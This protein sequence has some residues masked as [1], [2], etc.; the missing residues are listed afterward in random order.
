VEPIVENL[1]GATATAA[2]GPDGRE[3][4]AAFESL[5]EGSALTSFRLSIPPE[6]LGLRVASLGSRRAKAQPP[7][8]A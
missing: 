2:V 6:L 1:R 4:E 8:D 7:T 5:L 3:L